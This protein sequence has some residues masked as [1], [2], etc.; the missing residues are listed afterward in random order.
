MENNGTKLQ[1]SFTISPWRS[2]PILILYFFVGMFVGQ[3]VGSLLAMGLFGLNFQETMLV[4]TNF[5]L[6][7]QWKVYSLLY[8][9][10]L[11][12]WGLYNR[13]TPVYETLWAQGYCS[14][15]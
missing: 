1:D 14:F 15:V 6:G 3:F 9:V 12:G 7:P 13:P 8:T 5:P 11:C 4:V 2:L 10:W